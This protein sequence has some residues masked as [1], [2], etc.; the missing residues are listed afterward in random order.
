M[1]SHSRILD[2]LTTF[3]PSL[4]QIEYWLQVPGAQRDRL[5]C[6]LHSHGSREFSSDC[7][8]S[9]LYA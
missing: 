3:K 9:D 1:I 6:G 5:L 8:F 4:D 2:Y 7:I